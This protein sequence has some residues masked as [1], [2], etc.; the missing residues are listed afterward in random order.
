M[1]VFQTLYVTLQFWCDWRSNQVVT[2]LLF[3]L[4][5]FQN[6]IFS[7]NSQQILVNK[8]SNVRQCSITSYYR[9][10]FMFF[11]LW[12]FG[13][14]EQEVVSGLGFLE[15]HL[16]EKN[17]YWQAQKQGSNF[18]IIFYSFDIG[19][20]TM[21]ELSKPFIS[22]NSLKFLEKYCGFCSSTSLSIFF[23]IFNYHPI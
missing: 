10:T 3:F 17:K 5:Q 18:S 7:L 21:K 22:R 11:F 15:K 1:Y 16:S 20:Y 19:S 8:V 6:S 2:N 13:N 9:D 12:K 4:T 14:F 23:Q